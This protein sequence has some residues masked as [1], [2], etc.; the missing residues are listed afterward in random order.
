[1]QLAAQATGCR[2]R[3]R[4]PVTPVGLHYADRT[5]SS[6]RR[7]GAG[8]ELA[9]SS[10]GRAVARRGA[11]PRPA[12]TLAGRECAGRPALDVRPEAS[13]AAR[14][15]SGRRTHPRRRAIRGCGV[16]AG[17]VRSSSPASTSGTGRGRH[18]YERS[19]RSPGRCAP[20]CCSPRVGGRCGRRA[21]AR[22]HVP[23]VGCARA[24]FARSRRARPSRRQQAL[25]Y[26][27]SV[28]RAGPPAADLRGLWCPGDPGRRLARADA[29]R[30]GAARSKAAPWSGSPPGVGTR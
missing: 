21:S 22:L 23:S 11:G 13:R 9:G 30:R 4:Y 28:R 27:L 6:R 19:R 10:R 24:G 25:P 12:S 16:A 1:M 5:S 20:R 15:G 18:A 14:G 26:R 3:A 29:A 17:R 7:P 8:G 2:S